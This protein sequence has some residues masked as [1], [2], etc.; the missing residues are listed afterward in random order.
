MSG[1]GPGEKTGG[2]SEWTGDQVCGR[3]VGES[4]AALCLCRVISELWL[5]GRKTSRSGKTLQLLFLSNT[6]LIPGARTFSVSVFPQI[7]HALLLLKQ[8]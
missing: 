4:Q 1:P 6:D 2:T 8:R 3:S 7:L 5:L